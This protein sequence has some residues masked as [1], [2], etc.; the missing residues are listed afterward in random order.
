VKQ[1]SFN[2]KNVKKQYP[3]YKLTVLDNNDILGLIALVEYLEEERIEIK[4]LAVSKD[5]IGKGKQFDGIAGCLI[6]FACKQALLKF[7]RFPCV[8]LIPKTEIK[9]H[10]I[11]KYGMTDAGWHLF[12]EGMSLF[13]IVKEYLP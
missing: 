9:Q 2:W 13:N 1:F 11:D 7:K 3:V 5:N 12:L 6:A 4:L 8:S 10:Y